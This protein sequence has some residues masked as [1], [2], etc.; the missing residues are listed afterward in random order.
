MWKPMSPNTNIK[1]ICFDLGG[2][3][4]RIARHWREVLD[5]VGIDEAAVGATEEVWAGQRKVQQ[6]FETGQIGQDEYFSEAAAQ[7]DG[8]STDQFIEAFDAWHD[9]LFPNIDKLLTRL[10]EHPVPTACLSN[11]NSRHWDCCM[12]DDP[13]YGHLQLLDHRF[14]SHLIGCMKPAD[15]IY[16]HVEQQ[17]DVKPE[18]ILFFDDYAVNIQAADSRGWH[19]RLIDPGDDPAA[20][21]TSHLQQFNIL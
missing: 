5:R 10:T 12:G 11:T 2:V 6:R 14:A 8:I 1:L 4:I 18:S 20:Q 15:A 21:M 9:G 13:R 19:A 16:A 7:F 17:A 3:L